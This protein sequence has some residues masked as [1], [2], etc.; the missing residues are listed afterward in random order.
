MKRKYTRT[1]RWCGGSFK[2]TKKNELYCSDPHRKEQRK[3]THKKHNKKRAKLDKPLGTVNISPHANPDFTAEAKTVHNEYQRTFNPSWKDPTLSSLYS[4]GNNKRHALPGSGGA[5]L[6]FSYTYPMM[7]CGPCPECREDI[8]LKDP[9]RGEVTCQNCGL[10][11]YGP[12]HFKIKYPDTYARMASTHLDVFYSENT[13]DPKTQ[14]K[15]MSIQ[16]VAWDRFYNNPITITSSPIMV[17]KKN[18]QR[19][20]TPN[21]AYEKGIGVSN[22]SGH[23]SE[24]VTPATPIPLST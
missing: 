11:I 6:S 4:K 14:H 17:H 24:L 5:S 2:T 22:L 10:T 16:D 19:K 18:S 8:R 9:T 12:P 20:I 7:A 21:F 13:K 23:G 1:C 15:K 3:E